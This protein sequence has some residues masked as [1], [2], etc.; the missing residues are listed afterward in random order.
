MYCSIILLKNDVVLRMISRNETYT[1]AES[2]IA[3]V[4]TFHDDYLLSNPNA[5]MNM[6]DCVR[7]TASMTFLGA[8]SHYYIQRDIR[9]GPLRLQ[10]TDSHASNI[11]VDRDWN[12]TSLVDL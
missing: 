5:V 6:D 1:A 7:Q 3:D 9:N 10:L 11:F 4:L 2:Y 12:M 8:L